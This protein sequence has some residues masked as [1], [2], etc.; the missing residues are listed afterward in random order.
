MSNV[1]MTNN[2]EILSEVILEEKQGF[3]LMGG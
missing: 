2:Q 3:D 1:Y